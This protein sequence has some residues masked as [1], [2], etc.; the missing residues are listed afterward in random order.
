MRS[1]GNLHQRCCCPWQVSASS[2]IPER[3]SRGCLNNTELQW[4]VDMALTY[5]IGI[6]SKSPHF[7]HSSVWKPSFQLPVPSF[8]SLKGSSDPQGPLG[9]AVWQAKSATE[10]IFLRSRPQQWVMEFDAAML[11]FLAPQMRWLWGTCFSADCTPVAHVVTRLITYFTDYFPFS[12]PL[13][14]FIGMS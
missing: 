3:T 8:L 13:H 4:G 14:S 6:L 10:W 2:D 1:V 5:A 9:P 7:Y 11:H 12:V